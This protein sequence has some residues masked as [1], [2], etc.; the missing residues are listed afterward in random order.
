MDSAVVN[1]LAAGV[2][3]SD[4]DLLR[5][6]RA[7][8]VRHGDRNAWLEI[9]LDEGKN[10]HIRRMMESLGFQVLRLVRISIGP[11]ALGDLEK[12]GCRALTPEEKAALDRAM[13]V[14]ESA[15]LGQSAVRHTRPARATKQK[16]RNA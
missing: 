7:Q 3:T 1:A 16:K 14:A 13:R 12:G 9:V 8:I 6:K 2:T 10:R 5:A 15:H 4:G 11:L